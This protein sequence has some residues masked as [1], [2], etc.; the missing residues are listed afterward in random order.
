MRKI[1]DWLS[2]VAFKAIFPLAVQI[3]GQPGLNWHLFLQLSYAKSSSRENKSSSQQLRSDKET[4]T[5]KGQDYY[6]GNLNEEHQHARQNSG[7]EF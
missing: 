4:N 1:L 3:A 5:Q 7:R 2:Q 6:L